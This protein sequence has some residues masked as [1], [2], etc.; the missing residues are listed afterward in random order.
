[1]TV[2]D[3]RPQLHAAG[4]SD[5]SSNASQTIVLDWDRALDDEKHLRHCPVCGCSDLYAKK[6]VPQLTGFWLLLL[7]AIIVMLIFGLPM[8]EWLL[9][10]LI[11]VFFADLIIYKC[12][13]R[14]LICYQC[15]SEYQGFP[16]S[17]VYGSWEATTAEKYLPAS[18]KD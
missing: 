3:P 5:Q 16:M 4:E 14:V 11:C 13:K 10:A 12:L 18:K 8:I 17:K 6:K 9:G 2:K 15:G 1:M 7:A